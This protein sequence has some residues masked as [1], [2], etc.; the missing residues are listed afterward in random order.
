[1]KLKLLISI[2]FLGSMALL[3]TQDWADTCSGTGSKGAASAAA[4][5]YLLDASIKGAWSFESGST[6]VDS[7]GKQ[8]NLSEIHATNGF[9]NAL[10]K[11]GAQSSLHTTTNTSILGILTDDLD[12][13][14]PGKA[15]YTGLTVLCWYRPT[16]LTDYGE[17]ATCFLDADYV[18][19]LWNLRI[20]KTGS[21]YQT[22]LCIR[23]GTSTD[24][25]ITG[26]TNL[27]NAT[28]YF[29]AGTW[30]GSNENLYI[31]TDAVA[32]ALDATPLSAAVTPKVAAGNLWIGGMKY[33]TAYQWY[34]GGNIDML[35]IFNRALFITEIT[36]IY[37][38]NVDGSK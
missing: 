18:P 8:V 3:S 1:M 19:G 37:N 5:N 22:Q 16:A 7:A 9:D 4:N 11:W 27:A 29:I 28:N 15:A 12:A 34:A 33:S 26:T 20:K 14:F 13:A 38:H 30:D 10:A 35:C 32:P 21:I 36:E 23:S 2:L 24:T 31:G 17:I 25:I 6:L